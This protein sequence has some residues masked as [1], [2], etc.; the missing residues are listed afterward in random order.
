[1][2]SQTLHILLIH[3]W[4]NPSHRLSPS[5]P[6]LFLQG[7]DWDGLAIW[8]TLVYNSESSYLSL[9]TAGITGMYH[10]TRPSLT[11]CSIIFLFRS[12]ASNEDCLA[13]LTN[14]MAISESTLCHTNHLPYL[15]ETRSRSLP[16]LSSPTLCDLGFPVV[17]NPSLTYSAI[18]L[19]VEVSSSLNTFPLL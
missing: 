17:K 19:S 2:I 3:L 7:T 16:S 15:P 18:S 5:C 4:S 8:I 12:Q 10:Q 11:F 6:G 14:Y 9:Q 1:V 13:V